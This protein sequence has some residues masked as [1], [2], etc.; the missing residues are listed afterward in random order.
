MLALMRWR[1]DERISLDENDDDDDDDAR[2]HLQPAW[3]LSFAWACHLCG[4]NETNMELEMYA[5]PYRKSNIVSMCEQ[6]NDEE[7][8]IYLMNHWRWYHTH[9]KLVYYKH[10]ERTL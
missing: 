1:S 5:I 3:A 9:D 4:R 8:I 7:N 6:E 2:P 10:D